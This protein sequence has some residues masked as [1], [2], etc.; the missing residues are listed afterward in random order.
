MRAVTTFGLILWVIGCAASPRR[1]FDSSFDRAWDEDEHNRVVQSR[2]EYLKWVSLFYDGSTFVQG[3]TARQ[4]ELCQALEPDAAREAEPRLADFGRLVAA[5]WAKD[6][7]L[8]RIDSVLVARMADILEK[9]REAGRL[10]EVLEALTN[11][12]RS[13]IAGR[14]EAEAITA[15]RYEKFLARR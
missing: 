11:D 2:K 13:V 12:V 6:N 8:R 7:R 1:P 14:Q 5:E 3:W 4:A 10:L 15:E 9:A